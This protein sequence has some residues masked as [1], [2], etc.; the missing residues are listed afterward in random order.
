MYRWWSLP[1]A[2]LYSKQGR[3]LARQP[4]R[5]QLTTQKN[6]PCLPR[7]HFA[8]GTTHLIIE[9]HKTPINV[10]NTR[11]NRDLFIE[12]RRAHVAAMR[13]RHGQQHSIVELHIFVMK[14]DRPAIID[15]RHFHPDQVVSVVN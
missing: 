13:F 6:M 8:P 14:S 2:L 11:R 12:P 15:A 4:D 9:S 1:P 3:V 10:G 5:P 7:S